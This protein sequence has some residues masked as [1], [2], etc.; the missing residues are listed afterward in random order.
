MDQQG[1]IPHGNHV[2][3]VE[4]GRLSQMFILRKSP[5][6]STTREGAECLKC[7]SS[8][9]ARLGSQHQYSFDPD[10]STR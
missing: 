1:Y 2:V 6:M 9:A 4:K 3:D 10:T 8:V 5:I 7:L